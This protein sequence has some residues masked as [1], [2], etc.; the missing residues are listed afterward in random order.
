[1]PSLRQ[2]LPLDR[3]NAVVFAAAT[4]LLAAVVSIDF[5]S[6]W[7]LLL[8]YLVPPMAVAWL[9]RGYWWLVMTVLAT[10][11]WFAARCI[12]PPPEATI[13]GVRE[14]W[15]Q[16]GWILVTARLG[17][18]L[19]V[20]FL[21]SRLR[22]FSRSPNS[23]TSSHDSTGLLSMMG[24]REALSRRH[25]IDLAASGPVAMLLL[26]V[27]RK[28]SAFG[29][30]STEHAALV[31]AVIGKLLLNHSRAADLCVRVSPNHFLVIM[32]NS[33]RTI[34]ATLD[35]A[36]Q[37]AIPELTRTLDNSVSVSTLLL[38]C[39]GT[40]PSLERMRAHAVNR[41]VTLKVLGQGHYHS[42]EWQPSIGV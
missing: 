12:A 39:P 10:L 11:L 36:V 30:Q 2:I 7:T 37:D 24:L 15:Q 17:P 34:A 28:V 6:S 23:L 4:L 27:E 33:D 14:S 26:D 35:A 9:V 5:F 16:L 38:Y 18:M 29:G 1:M 31:G 21:C 40:C 8:L 41:L 42:E 22:Q 32:L 19:L 20:A 3:W 13:D 25:T